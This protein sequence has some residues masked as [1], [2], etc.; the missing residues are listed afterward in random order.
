MLKLLKRLEGNKDVWFLLISS[1]LFFLL[2]FP[3]FFEPY[4]YGDEGI[5]EVIG[6][7][8]RHGRFLYVGIWD[9]KP[10]LLYLLYG[11]VDG[12]QTLIRILSCLV[13]L[14]AVIVFFFLAKT[15][16]KRPTPTYVSTAIF[17]LLLALPLV[18]GNIANAENFMVL[19]T[20]SAAFLLVKTTQQEKIDRN[21]LVAITL[22]GLLLGLSFL[23]KVVGLFDYAS[24]GIFVLIALFSYFLKH[25]RIFLAAIFVYSIGF[26]IPIGI[27]ILFYLSQNQLHTF[28]FS[29]LFTNVGY[30]DYGN[31]FLG[32]HQGLL[33]LKLV[34]LLC[35]VVV[36]FLWRKKITLSTLFISLWL[37]FSLFSALFSQRPYTHYLLVLLGSFSLLAGSVIFSKKLRIPLLVGFVVLVIFLAKNFSLY[38]KTTQYYQNFISYVIG[39]KDTLSYQRFFDRVTP[40][41]YALSS[42]INTHKKANDT[43]FVW[44][45]SG[46]IYRL[47]N[48]LPPGRYIV[49]YHIQATPQTLQETALALQKTPPRFVVLLSNSSAFP[50]R[51]RHYKEVFSVEGGYVYERTY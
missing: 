51:M 47:T 17:G 26:I 28:L 2:R 40:R 11:L 19:S 8:L 42:Y 12:N 21:A 25:I 33:L 27:T 36:V 22:S 24:F 10:P 50:F 46:Q 49:E 37:S 38:S 1:F 32:I 7:A 15:L 43:L 41:D 16:F 39:S 3:S 18:E 14:A 23:T 30:V 29:T 34:L 13:G 5:Y 35:V 4:W 45:N 48:M 20:I 6:Y 9:N 44:G 31:T